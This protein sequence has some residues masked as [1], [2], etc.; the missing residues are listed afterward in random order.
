VTRRAS[1]SRFV[2]HALWRHASSRRAQGNSR[3]A[4]N[5]AELM[6]GNVEES[7]T[8]EEIGEFLTRYGFP[9]FSSIERIPGAGSRP[10]ALVHFDDVSADGLRN[11]Q[12]R[13]H[14]LFW[15]GRTISALL[16]PGR[17]ES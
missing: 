16:L 11:L 15:N 8:D 10:A 9:Q 7:V 12:P 2:H 13:I 4:I 5:M 17:E 3:G 1:A 6:L 14:N